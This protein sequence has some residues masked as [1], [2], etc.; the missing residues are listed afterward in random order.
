MTDQK[1]LALMGGLLDSLDA[2]VAA[3]ISP[4]LSEALTRRVAWC[5][6]LPA[7]RECEGRRHHHPEVRMPPMTDDVL[8][9]RAVDHGGRVAAAEP[10]RTDQRRPALRFGQRAVVI[11]LWGLMTALL[12]WH[13]FQRLTS[14]A[15]AVHPVS[16]LTGAVL[17]GLGGAF[18]VWL[19]VQVTMRLRSMRV[20]WWVIVPAQ[21]GAMLVAV[22]IMRGI[23]VVVYRVVIDHPELPLVPVGIG[24]SAEAIHYLVLAAAA[25]VVVLTRALRRAAVFDRRLYRT[26]RQV[27]QDVLQAGLRR[28]NAEMAPRT[29]GVAV[30][31]ALDCLPDDIERAER[32]LV[33]AAGVMREF[34]L[35]GELDLVAVDDERAAIDG[36]MADTASPATV[37]WELT[38]DTAQALVPSFALWLLVVT[39][40]GLAPA[41]PRVVRARRAGWRGRHLELLIGPDANPA[42]RVPPSVASGGAASSDAEAAWPADDRTALYTTRARLRMLFGATARLDTVRGVADR[43]WLRLV[44]PWQTDGDSADA[45]IELP[46]SSLP[47]ADNVTAEGNVALPVVTALRVVWAGA[48]A[49]FAWYWMST[50]SGVSMSETQTLAVLAVW[51]GVDPL[52]ASAIAWYTAARVPLGVDGGNWRRVLWHV[53]ALLSALAISQATDAAGAHWLA[54][55]PSARRGGDSTPARRV[56]ALALWYLLVL[57]V[58]HSQ[59]LTG[60]RRAAVDAWRQLRSRRALARASRREAELRALKAQ[61]NPHFAGN[62][63]HAAIALLRVDVRESV[64][65]LQSLLTLLQRAVRRLEQDEV[66]LTVELAE[67]EPFL[68]IERIRLTG[69]SRTANLRVTIDV[70]P[71]LANVAVPHLAL[72]PLLENAVRHGLVPAGRGG[73]IVIRARAQDGNL[74]VVEVED[75]GVGPGTSPIRSSASGM[76]T[77]IGTASLRSRLR[78][79]YG[80]LGRFELSAAPIAGSIARMVVPLRLLN[81]GRDEV[82]TIR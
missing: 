79:M 24:V 65:L 29:L 56:L 45:L 21:T 57:V 66:S 54:D 71:E 52:V 55:L 10:R 32:A 31:Q 4:A 82:L 70:P 14:V 61:L 63:L 53:V 38:G 13:E 17:E 42:K 46:G 73:H 22:L 74:L 78:S 9:E 80:S 7:D 44:L 30:K 48:A 18:C 28:L 15:A 50:H 20:R 26:I 75:D 51:G 58:A 62:A 76:G 36:F 77:G 16:L 11:A 37:R 47:G 59:V 1:R 5:L 72:Q 12:Q 68:A 34:I 2:P 33:G 39:T 69:A 60:R 67:L 23:A 19:A 41:T 81:A 25:Q 40:P 3:P 6:L 8:G 27:E 64:A 49:L 43:A 35:G